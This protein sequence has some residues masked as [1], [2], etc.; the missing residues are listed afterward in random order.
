MTDYLCGTIEGFYGRTW[1]WP[2]RRAMIDFLQQ[3]QFN[4]YI[5]APKADRNLRRAWRER[6]RADDFSELLALRMHCRAQQIQFGI[7]FSPWGLQSE[8]TVADRAALAEKFN[9][10]NTLDSDVLCI[11]FDDMPGAINDLAQR[12][13][14]IVADI[15]MMSSARRFAI[16]PTYYSF[17]PV[18]EKVFGAMPAHYLEALSAA[19]PASVD[20]FWTGPLVLSPGYS[21]ND[22]AAISARIGRKPLL[23]DNYPVNDGKKI[24]QFLHLL[25]VQQRPAQLRAWC[26]GHFANAMNQPLLSRLPLASLASSYRLGER[27]DAE[28][29]WM[30]ELEAF[31]SADL[32][33][34]LRRDIDAFQKRG[35][36]QLS[37]NERKHMLADYRECNDPAAL[38]VI[39][40]LQ[41]GYQFDPQCL[42]N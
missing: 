35:L 3:Q 7:G 24:S 22:I 34:L 27:Y 21:E 31:I 26:S 1:P 40:W 4:T 2:A 9:H 41:S 14:T 12:Q 10:L 17:D 25:P 18:L 13:T 19:L 37:E 6:H 11:L 39:E 8:Y 15:M 30:T 5:Y 42:T 38:E 29:F 33:A 23:W 32:A 36:D 20:I 16:C 28:R